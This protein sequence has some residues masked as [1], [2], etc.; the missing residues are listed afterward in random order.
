M[1]GIRLP[2]IPVR[3]GGLNAWSCT[4]FRS[5]CSSKSKIN[6]NTNSNNTKEPVPQ[7]YNDAYRQ[8]QN[9]DFMTAAKI[10]FTSPPKE[11]KFGFDFHLVQFFFACMPSLAVYLV[12]QYARYEIRRMEAEAEQKKKQKEEEEKAKDMESSTME[13]EGG[14]D[15]ELLKVKVRLDALEEA[16]KE[17]VDETKKLSTGMTK[18]PEGGREDQPTNLQNISKPSSSAADN[19]HG[20]S[21]AGELVPDVSGDKARE[22]NATASASQTGNRNSHESKK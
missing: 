13:E 12:A 6:S 8:L 1:R 9:L 2:I 10:L 7:S 15:P 22:F 18:D 14:S 3:V 11:K 16:V 5:L 17:I 19:Q 21:T 20:K 4:L